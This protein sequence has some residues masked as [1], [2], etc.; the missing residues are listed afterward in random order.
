MPHYTFRLSLKPMMGCILK[1][2]VSCHT[3]KSVWSIS[4][5][6]ELD[7]FCYVSFFIETSNFITYLNDC[8]LT[9]F[10]YGDIHQALL[11]GWNL[12]TSNSSTLILHE[13]THLCCICYCQVDMIAIWLTFCFSICPG[14][15]LMH[16]FKTSFC[17]PGEY[18][19][20]W[21]FSCCHWFFCCC[22]WWLCC[23]YWWLSCC[24]LCLCCCYWWHSCC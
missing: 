1:T 10:S 22:Y 5:S 3:P 23:C 19:R 14:P 12:H 24:C 21:I 15:S 4:A 9:L 17:C 20:A 13:C 2:I 6:L 16:Y 11:C 8:L 18:T 7:S